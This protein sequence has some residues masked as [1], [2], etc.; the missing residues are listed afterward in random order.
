MWY[1]VNVEE[2]KGLSTLRNWTMAHVAIGRTGRSETTSTSLAFKMAH[3]HARDAV[4]ADLQLEKL[5]AVIKSFHPEVLHVKSRAANR[6]IY[7]QRPDFG[8]QPDEE[9][10]LLLKSYSVLRSTD[11]LFV[12]A[13]GLSALA[14]DMHAVHFLKTILP[15]LKSEGYSVGPVVIAQQARVAIGDFIAHHLEAKLVVVLIGERPG[16]SAE[17]SMGAYLTFHPTPG[18]TDEARNCISNI[19]T[20]GLSYQ[21]ASAKL[22]YLIQESFRRGLSGVQLKDE[23]DNHLLME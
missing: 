3:A 18:T 1:I 12:V 13:D 15:A 7:L 16:L 2:N 21:L 14:I 17:D 5:D 22:M 6:D 20:D 8:R 23:S 10:T 19:R 11:V 9:S 4:H